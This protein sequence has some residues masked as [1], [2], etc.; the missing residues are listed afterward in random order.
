MPMTIKRA[1][2][3]YKKL[4][5]QYGLKEG[6]FDEDWHIKNARLNVGGW[7]F[8]ILRFSMSASVDEPIYV[9]TKFIP[10]KSSKSFTGW[11]NTAE[12]VSSEE[13]AHKLIDNIIKQLKDGYIKHKKEWI[14]GDFNEC[15]SKSN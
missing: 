14:E 8:E 11:T 15:C 10:L 1:N 6:W 12:M 5:I 9:F 2:V 3:L 4:L 13:E 7:D